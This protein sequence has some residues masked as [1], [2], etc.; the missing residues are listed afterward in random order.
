MLATYMSEY[1]TWD[2]SVIQSVAYSVVFI[3]TALVLSILS[4]LITRL[5]RAISLGWL[6]RLLGCV[7]GAAKWVLIMSVLLNIF[8]L[9]DQHFN[10]LQPEKKAESKAYKPMLKIASIA[11]ETAS[12][13]IDNDNLNESIS[14]PWQ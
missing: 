5:L 14:F 9:A 2:M 6:N 10:L 1:V 8:D 7:F 13:N 3:G 11:W 4:R 12:E